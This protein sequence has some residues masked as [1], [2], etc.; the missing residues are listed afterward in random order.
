MGKAILQGLKWIGIAIG[1]LLVALAVWIGV[2]QFSDEAQDAPVLPT[3]TITPTYTPTPTFTPTPPETPTP[4]Q[5][6]QKPR[7]LK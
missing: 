5:T 1:G 6:L 3:A 4:T 7:T 2:Y